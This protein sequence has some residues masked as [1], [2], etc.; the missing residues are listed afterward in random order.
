MNNSLYVAAHLLVTGLYFLAAW[1]AW[2]LLS[3]DPAV[4]APPARADWPLIVLAVLHAELLTL[5]ILGNDEFRFGFAQ[6]LSA[7]LWLTVVVLWIEGF[8]VP[9][10]GL[11]PIVLPVAGICAALPAVFHGSV[12]PQAA[13]SLAFRLHLLVAI[14]AY[15]L[16]TI[17]ALHALLMAA[18]DRQLHAATRAG[19]AGRMFRGL[20][21]L[22][23]MEKLLFGLIGA[24]F[25]LLTATVV[26]G[27]F[28]SEY[29][30]GRALRFEH[31]TIFTLAAWVVFGGLLAGR[32]IFGWRG[33]IALRWTLTG[34]VMLLLAYVGSRFVY[35]V[36][37]QRF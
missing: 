27:I 11:H 16:L 25:L 18:L 28:F 22:L 14:A 3:D 32:V 7:T 12:V 33:R 2:H 26:S 29:L 10:R 30:F 23:G 36:I 4:S 37:L 21:P 31:K 5:S 34:F 35:E 9:M 24:G 8:F 15:T 13:G 6:A 17:A 19:A 1:R 20:P